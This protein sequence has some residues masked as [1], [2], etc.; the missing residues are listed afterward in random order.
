MNFKPLDNE[1]QYRNTLRW[2]EQFKENINEISKIETC[3]EVVGSH[4]QSSGD[5]NAKLLLNLA[6]QSS[7]SII[8]LLED[9]ARDYEE[10]QKTN[11][12]L[13]I[14]LTSP[15]VIKRWKNYLKRVG[16]ESKHQESTAVANLLNFYSDVV[17]EPI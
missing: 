4:P 13:T 1:V 11:E 10:R 9:E 12:T 5:G 3:E 7:K 16:Y 8:A 17:R 15:L 2:I 6:I 14:T